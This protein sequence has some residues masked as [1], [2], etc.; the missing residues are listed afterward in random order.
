VVGTGKRVGKTALAIQLARVCAQQLDVVVVAMGRGG[1]PEPELRETPPSVEELL[2]LARSGRHAASDYLEDALLGEIVSI[3][4]RRCGGGLAG[5]VFCSNV[6][7]A[8]EMALERRPDLVVFEGSG[9]ALPPIATDR[10]VLVV[11]AHQDAEL[12]CGYL[13][14]YRILISDLLVLSFAQ[15]GKR[16]AQ[17]RAA[18]AALRPDLQVIATSMRPRPLTPVAGKKVALF[19]TAPK[20][21][22]RPLGEHLEQSHGAEVV[23]VSG[24][25]ARRG[26]LAKEMAQIDAEVFLVELKA[27][28]VDV[29]IEEAVARG[30]EVGLVDNELVPLEGEADL[31]PA[32]LELAQQAREKATVT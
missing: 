22:L 12:A 19:T 9:A 31:E 6:A 4:A 21:A 20:E 23:H 16:L 7:Q 10:R 30:C 11:S 17:L 18:I 26:E 28:A 3:G 25:L 15:P 8:A 2:E 14:A 24:S 13:N 1:P 27:A 32:L 5:A 29:V